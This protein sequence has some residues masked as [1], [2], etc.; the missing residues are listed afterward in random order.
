MYVHGPAPCGSLIFHCIF[1]FWKPSEWTYW[2]FSRR[3]FSADFPILVFCWFSHF[4]IIFGFNQIHE[5]FSKFVKLF[6][7]RNSFTYIICSN[8]LKSQWPMV[9]MV[10]GLGQ[11]DD[12]VKQ[13]PSSELS[14]RAIC[15][16]LM[17]G[18]NRLWAWAPAGQMA[19]KALYRR[20]P[21]HV[22][23][24]V[25]LH[26]HYSWQPTNFSF[27]HRYIYLKCFII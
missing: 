20:P 23:T 8:L 25:T 15:S 14:D 11:N 17:G 19:H 16:C 3:F 2:R 4:V 12:R 9:Q 10:S 27:F 26:V 18:P 1:F 6:C 21:F 5:I 24:S 13:Q 7:T 22:A